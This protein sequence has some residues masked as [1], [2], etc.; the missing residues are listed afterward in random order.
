MQRLSAVPVRVVIVALVAAGPAL[1]RAE[2]PPAELL[3]ELSVAMRNLIEPQFIEAAGFGFSSFECRVETELNPGSRFNCDAVDQKGEEISY[4]FEVDDDLMAAVVLA[5]QSMED[6]PEGHRARFEAPCRRFLDSYAEG[7]WTS[8]MDTLDPTLLESLSKEEIRAQLAPTRGA[9]GELRV[10]IPLTYSLNV[11]G[12][13]EIQYAL[14]CANGPA[15]ARLGV[16]LEGDGA[17]IDAFTVGPSPGSTLHTKLL[18]IEGRD[19]I[20][21]TINEPVDHIDAPIDLLNSVG[22]AVEGTA[23]LADGRELRIGVV[24]Q[25]RPDDFDNIDYRFQILDVP[26]LLTRAYTSPA[27]PAT[28]V[29]CPKPVAPDGGTMTCTVDLA[30][31]QALAVTIARRS[32]DHRIVDSQPIE[33]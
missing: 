23:T 27:D 3:A 5:S 12:R 32:G 4:T 2:S 21:D 11:S 26:W 10:V 31:G 33:D 29:D 8:L 28:S 14:D 15:L 9:L 30:S 16:I 17:K 19:R 6:L 1:A 18:L 25:G 20:A 13:H 24:Q 7:D 22:D